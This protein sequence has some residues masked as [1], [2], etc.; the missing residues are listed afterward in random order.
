[1]VN[2][3]AILV[4]GI[5][6]MVL[7]F[8]WYGP[9]FGKP[10]MRLSGLSKKDV[11]KAKQKSMTGS[12]ILGFIS[13]L[14]MIWVLALFFE[15]LS[16]TNYMTAITTS[17]WV[18]LGFMGTLTLS[19]FIWENKSFSLWILNNGY[20]VINLLIAALILVAWP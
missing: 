9:F 10:W 8:L 5:A 18:W 1:M 14:V 2:Y 6:S 7:G 16:V 3:L 20:N 13:S 12:I 4:A 19:S 11:N 17:L 15:M